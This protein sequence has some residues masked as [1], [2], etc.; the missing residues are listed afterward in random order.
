MRAIVVR[1]FGDPSV[2]RYEEISDPRPA[3]GEV[4]IAV[5]AAGT[6]PVDTGNRIDGGWAGLELPWIPGYEVAGVI[7]EMGP[8]VTGFEPGQRVVAM[9]DFPQYGGGYADLAVV[10]ATHIAPIADSVPFEAAAALPVAAGTAWDILERL[11]LSEGDRLVVLG[12]SG[13]VGSYLLQM[14]ALWGIETIAIG[15]RENHARLR[16][17]GAYSCIDYTSGQ[18]AEDIL[19][20]GRGDVH[21]IADL[22]GGKAIVP[23][24]GALRQHG[25]IAAVEPPELDYGY[26]IDGNVTF[27]GVLLTMDAE[28]LGMLAGMLADGS[29][30]SSIAHLIPL[31]EAARA[32]HLLEGGHPGGKVILT[33]V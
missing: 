20:A 6:N 12:A 33:T 18:D 28:R 14:C 26:L 22:V 32:H 30:T 8:G 9:T 19:A 13:G 3:E 17:L 16:K 31:A 2:L 27:H 15:R 25:Q 29:M 23:W 11:K 5:R 1:R 10:P 4:R 24:L 7:D 21:A